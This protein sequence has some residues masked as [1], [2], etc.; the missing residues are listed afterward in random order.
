MVLDLLL[1]DFGTYALPG[2]ALIVSMVAVALS[3]YMGSRSTSGS[4]QA[5]RLSDL[6]DQVDELEEQLKECARD[7][8]RLE[9]QNLSLMQRILKLENGNGDAG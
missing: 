3:A 8:H 9:R 2:A 1:A 4:A 5:N 7:R 6:K